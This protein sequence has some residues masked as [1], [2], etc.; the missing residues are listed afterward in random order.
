MK[1]HMHA[2]ASL[3]FSGLLYLIFRSWGLFLASLISGICI[4]LDYLIDYMRQVGLPF[5]MERFWR[6]Y[7]KE[8]MINIRLFHGWEWLFLWGLIA[9]LSDWNLL[10]LGTLLGFGQHI[11]LDMIHMG[12][13]F[14][15]YSLIWRW[16]KGFV[17]DEIFRED[18][19]K[20]S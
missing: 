11:F 5:N 2:A 12:E 14:R 3:A 20:R 4:D 9:W 17:R 7:N 16:K 1:P 18:F 8:N 15:C 19:K 6:F 13:N 10:I